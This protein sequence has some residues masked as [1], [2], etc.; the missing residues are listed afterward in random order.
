MQVNDMKRFM[1]YEE[2]GGKSNPNKATRSISC[3]Y[4]LI[5]RDSAMFMLSTG[6]A[7]GY[8][9]GMKSVWFWHVGTSMNSGKTLGARL[10][11]RDSVVLDVQCYYCIYVVH[12]APVMLCT[13]GVV[14]IGCCV[15]VVYAM[16]CIDGVVYML[17][18]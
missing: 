7:E 10:L 15:H 1:V 8:I 9:N 11:G 13:Y 5:S 6:Y 17:F 12:V 3:G 2:S 16:L 14:S 4:E 18:M